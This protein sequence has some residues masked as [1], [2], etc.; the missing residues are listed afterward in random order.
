MIKCIIVDDEKVILDEL[1]SLI[2]QTAKV[3]LEGA[4]QAP[5]KALEKI[6]II[7]PDVVFLDIEMPGLNGIELAKK[8]AEFDRATQIVFVTAYEQ[9]ALKAFEVSAVHYLLKPLT[10]DKINDAIER[11]LH[12]KQMN[13]PKGNVAKPEFMSKKTAVDRISVKDKDNIIIIK[14]LDII[15][16]KSEN[17]QTIIVTK[18][19]SYKSWT[20]L[21]FWENKLKDLGF[22]R[23]HRSYVVNTY[24]INKMIHILGEYKELTLDYCDVNIPISRQKIN[25]IK[26]VLGVL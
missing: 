23:C 26:E 7:K 3:Q 12:V 8:I 4:Y 5:Y 16:F 14:I 17:R 2:E 15:Y 25:R 19:G 18:K 24:Y 1:R 21:Q 11:V 10:Q 13:A 22:I 6:R 9:Y 20:G